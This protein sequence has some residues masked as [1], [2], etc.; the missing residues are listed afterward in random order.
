MQGRKF[1]GWIRSLPPFQG[2]FDA[3]GFRPFRD[4]RNLGFLFAL[5]IPSICWPASAVPPTVNM[6]WSTRT[7]Q[8]SAPPP[9]GEIQVTIS[10]ASAE[11]VVG[12]EIWVG[13]RLVEV[14]GDLYADIFSPGEI[15]IA[16]SDPSQTSTGLVE[17]FVLAFE[18]GEAYRIE[19]DV[20]IAGCEPP[21]FDTVRDIVQIRVNADLSTEGKVSSLRYLGASE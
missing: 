5:V 3:P 17:Y 2:P 13:D 15:D 11:R 12:L 9:F 1:P 6:V 16:Y 20:E 10:V 4:A 19:Y 21:C 18:A 14:P 8:V 7:Y